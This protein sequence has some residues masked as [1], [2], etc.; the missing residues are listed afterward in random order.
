MAAARILVITNRKGG[1]G[2]TS[3]S[4]NLASEYAARGRKVLLIDL[5]SQS[6]C[7]VGLGVPQVRGAASAQSFLAGQNSLRQALRAQVL[8]GLDL[9]PADPLFNHSGSGDTS[10]ALGLAL[11]AEGLLGDYDL[12]VLDTPPSL[13]GLL[14]NAL[15]AADRVLVPFVPHFLSAEGVRQ[16]ARVIF[17]VASRGMNDKLKVLG[18]V[19]VMLDMRIGLHRE[20]CEDLGRQFGHARLLPGVR[21]DIRVAEAF[22]HGKPVRQHA[23]RSRAAQDYAGVADAV[24]RMWGVT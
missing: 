22:G 20:V 8:P 2:K 18:F 4:V 24:E 3:L 17:R 15:C 11:D 23:A 19:P 21:N 9:I 16:L 13:D 10:A 14:L 6:H 12:V 7:A 1:T 5:D